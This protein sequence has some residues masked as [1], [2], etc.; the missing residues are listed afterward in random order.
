MLIKS[1]NYSAAEIGQVLDKY[2]DKQAIIKADCWSA[3]FKKDC[4]A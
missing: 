1:K 2:V 4:K 3:W